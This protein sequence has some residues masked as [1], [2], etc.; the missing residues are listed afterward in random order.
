[1][2]NEKTCDNKT[3]SFCD[4]IAVWSKSFVYFAKRHL[5]K[6][7]FRLNV[8]ARLSSEGRST[9]CQIR[10]GGGDSPTDDVTFFCFRSSSYL[11][12]KSFD[13]KLGPMKRK[14]QR[15]KE[16]GLSLS[17]LTLAYFF[18]Y[19]CAMI[20]L[21]KEVQ[22]ISRLTF[23]YW[24]CLLTCPT[25]LLNHKLSVRKGLFWLI[26]KRWFRKKEKNELPTTIQTI[27]L[28]FAWLC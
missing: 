9:R 1:M 2:I 15:E 7:L 19:F 25:L 20:N 4:D 16:S 14:W 12:H 28:V 23:F 17:F 5:D 3:N 18:I 26:R 8:A 27:H 6:I 21:Y 13:F 24:Y 11:R 10:R 22:S